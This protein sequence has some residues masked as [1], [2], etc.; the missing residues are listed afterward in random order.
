MAGN[1]AF[2]ADPVR[3]VPSGPPP[4]YESARMARYV[5]HKASKQ[6]KNNVPTMSH[7]YLKK[8]ADIQ[9][10]HGFK[11]VSVVHRKGVSC[12]EMCNSKVY[13][14]NLMC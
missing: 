3:R 11:K 13:P 2:M 6:A 8:D 1:F 4:F 9:R 5:V 10:S 14:L 12:K 7:I